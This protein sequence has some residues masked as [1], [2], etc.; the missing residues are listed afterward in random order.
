M[1]F[2]GTSV[3]DL[4]RISHV[5]HIVKKTIDEGYQVVVVV[6]AMAGVTNQLVSYVEQT[7]PVYDTAEYDVVVSSGEQIT[8]GLM[9]IKLQSLGIPARSWLGWQVPIKTD[10][11][12]GKACIS[13]IDTDVIKKS[14]NQ[15]EV[16]VCAGFQGVSPAG[17]ITTLG[18][19]GSDLTAVALAAWLNAT[20]CDIYTDVDGIYTADPR[21]VKRAHKITHIS[22]EEM[23]E[24]ASLGA[25]VLQAQSVELAMRYKVPLYVLSSF[26]E[27]EGTFVTEKG[28]VVVHNK[29]TGV[30]YNNDEVFISIKDIEDHPQLLSYISLQFLKSGISFDMLSSVDSVRDHKLY[31]NLSFVVNASEQ[32]RIRG[33]LD[34]M[35]D[36]LGFSEYEVNA[37]VSRVSIVGANIR[38]DLS[39]AHDLFALL[40]ERGITIYALQTSAVQMSIII[41]DEYTE[42]LLRVLHDKYL[43]SP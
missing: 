25:R 6:S 5:A 24:M 29:I 35:K 9:A 37:E 19:S 2:G 26:E 18:R 17:R 31:K 30:S 7:S 1:K 39:L 32:E 10:H 16:A 41:P 36:V 42:L 11:I 13:C 8:S 12:H 22:Y 23:L 40:C 3:A 27:G 21:V 4:E 28:K 33:V 38:L 14:L 34:E 43:S 15:G 20:R